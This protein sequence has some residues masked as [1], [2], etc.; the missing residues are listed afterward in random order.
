M[1]RHWDIFIYTIQ[2]A[3]DTIKLTKQICLISD[4]ISVIWISS[5]SLTFGFFW[6][7]GKSAKFRS[8]YGRGYAL[9]VIKV[10]IGKIFAP[11]LHLVDRIPFLVRSFSLKKTKNSCILGW[12]YNYFDIWRLRFKNGHGM[13]LLFQHSLRRF[14]IWYSITSDTVVRIFSAGIN[15]YWCSVIYYSVTCSK[16]FDKKYFCFISWGVDWSQFLLSFIG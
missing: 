9:W 14:W 13:Y 12:L 5:Y 16:C 2:F 10:V 1:L 4:T 11:H 15:L 8:D 6:I 3:F 7:T